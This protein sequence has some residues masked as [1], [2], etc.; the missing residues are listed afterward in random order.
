MPNLLAH[1]L[2]AIAT[3]SVLGYLF[4]G[5]ALTDYAFISALFA[6]LPDLDLD[7]GE[8]RSPYGHSVGFGAL[9]LFLCVSGLNLT[10]ALGVLPPGLVLP[11]LTATVVGLG[12][13]LLLDS[14]GD[15]GIFTFPRRGDWGRLS[16]RVSKGRMSHIDFWV[17]SLSTVLLL[18]LF[19]LS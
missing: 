2:A 8:G 6:L 4:H 14:I 5:T 9:Y 17:S 18:V 15:P 11:L 19:A 12:T 1:A 13:H 16:L 7:G 10:S 3:H